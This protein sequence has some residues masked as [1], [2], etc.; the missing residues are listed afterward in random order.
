MATISKSSLKTEAYF[1][2]DYKH[3]Y[4][5]RKEWDKNSKN[6]MIIMIQPRMADT[7]LLEVT[8]VFVINNMHKMEFGSIEI[9]NLFSKV[10][11]KIN[12]RQ[13][14]DRLGVDFCCI[15]ME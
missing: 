6:A 13:S 3:R 11:T 14:R 8:T 7:M 4:L 5:L 15:G 1:S 10:D 12:P 2:D 9:V